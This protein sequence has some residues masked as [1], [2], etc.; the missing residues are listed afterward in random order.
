MKGLAKVPSQRYPDVLE[1]AKALRAALNN[2][3]GAAE[4]SMLG[5]FRGFFKK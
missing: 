2:D 1:F 3:K 5:K 4:T